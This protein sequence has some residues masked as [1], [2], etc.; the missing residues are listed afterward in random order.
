MFNWYLNLDITYQ[1]L[2]AGLF[3][4]FFTAL[5]ASIVFFFKKINNTVLDGMLGLAGGIMIAASFF[6][7]LNPAIEGAE[8]IGLTPWLTIASGFIFGGMLLFLAD[9]FFN[10]LFS[11][12]NTSNTSLKRSAMLISSITIHNIPEGLAIGVAFGSI[13]VSLEGATISSAL[14]LALGIAIQ[15]FPEGT[16]VSLPLRR[17]RFSRKN[18][19]LYGALSGIVEPISAVLGCI[20][21]THVQNILP[22][23]LAF[24]AGSMIYVVVSE[25]IPESQKNNRKNLMT[26][27]SIMGFV[28][29]MV[30]DVALG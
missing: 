11:N 1:V 27:F 14:M 29:M 6:S 5:G 9:I 26:L 17:E 16:A 4:W 22:F 10:K 3:T 21:V 7:L 24:A 8:K 13:A 18:A 15:N 2:L 30:L 28:L 25:L 12:H 23:L 19:F 20:L